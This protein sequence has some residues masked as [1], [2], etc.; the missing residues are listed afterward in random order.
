MNIKNIIK[1]KFINLK[2]NTT[3]TISLIIVIIALFL[4]I[5]NLY[6]QFN[7]TINK[8]RLA[9]NT[10]IGNVNLSN[11]TK[12]EAKNK[13]IESTYNNSS[14]I[15][16]KCEDKQAILMYKDFDYYN[17]IDKTIESLFNLSKKSI[18]LPFVINHTCFP[19]NI[20]LL[21]TEE[22]I[23]KNIKLISS[24]LDNPKFNAHVSCFNPVGNPMFTYEEGHDGYEIDKDELKEK[25][26]PILISRRG[27]EITLSKH[28]IKNNSDINDAQSSTQL[29][30]EFITISTNSENSNKNMNTA[31]KLINGTTL[32][33]GEEFSFNKIVGDSSDPSRGFLSGASILNGKVIMSYGGGICQAATTVYGAAIRANMTITERRNHTFKSSYVPYGEDATINYDN[34]DLKFRNDLKL[35]I[36]IKTNMEG[37]ILKCQIYGP[38]DDSYDKIEVKSYISHANGHTSVYSERNYYKNGKIIDKK[39]LPSSCYR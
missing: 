9:Q 38:K 1:D 6:T 17:N 16:V 22:S 36:Y 10:L 5:A 24:K 34:I 37:K 2:G 14:T 28:L 7:Y 39:P 33:P 8:E 30:S 26:I 11:L 31:M 25:L 4:L 35:P 19:I 27:G 23:D 18:N 15:V 21:P 32:D 20:T 29:I 12:E 13:I 3:N